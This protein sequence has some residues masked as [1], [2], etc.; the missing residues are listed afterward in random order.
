MRKKLLS[1]IL[2]AAMSVSLFGCG[3]TRDTADDYPVEIATETTTIE[4]YSKEDAETLFSPMETIKIT[5][6]SQV[7]V[8]K[9]IILRHEG[10]ENDGR[11][12]YKLPLA[13]FIQEGD[14]INSFTFVVE[15]SSGNIGEFK[16]AYGIT[17]AEDCPSAT[18]SC[19]H[20]TPDFT[21][22]TN[23]GYAELT[24]N[25]PNE[26]AD[27]VTPNGDVM[28]GYW[29]GDA[30]IIKLGYV[31]CTF[32][33]TKSVPYKGTESKAIGET[34]IRR[35]DNED[36]DHLFRIKNDFLPE[37]VVP[38]L[39]TYSFS[40][41]GNIKK[42]N[43]EFGFES[44]VNRYT[45]DDVAVWVDGNLAEISWF[46]PVEVRNYVA[47]KGEY[48]FDY[49]W[50]E[51]SEITL[52]KITVVYSNAEESSKT[53]TIMGGAEDYSQQT[54]NTSFRRAREISNAIRVGWNLG[55][56]LE[57]YNTGLSGLETET[58][59]GNPITTEGM[60]KSVK[61]AGFNAVRIPV[62][63]AEHMD[64]YYNIDAEWLDRIQEVVDYA[65]N[66]DM[67]VIV[68][69]HHDDYIWFVPNEEK[70]EENSEKLKAIWRQIAN[71]FIDYG[72]RLLF[73]G[74]NEPRTVGS[75]ME[76]MGGTADERTVVNR[77]ENDFVETVR[78][79][80]GNNIDRT[81]IVTSYAASAETVAINDVIV[82]KENGNIIFSVHYYAPWEF[83]EGKITDFTDQG[84]TQLENKFKEL[85]TKFID[86]GTP[87]IID[88]FGCGTTT[89]EQTRHDYYNYYITT[90][91]KYG[92]KCFVWD[93]G[94]TEG[95]DGFGI[96][97]REDNYKW[98]TSVL[99]GIMDK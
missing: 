27:Y 65:Y 97:A 17:V 84:K 40:A 96:F 41:N 60:I 31:I 66:S 50:S 98:N 48:L 33:R 12:M 61:E 45:G 8:Q 16:G 24:W 23:G 73:E 76:W 63:W 38:Q 15:S 59:W 94:L 19:F 13:D 99:T 49:G 74:M 29:W 1:A 81:L 91:R 78:A 75:S 83:T 30:E 95:K 89:S 68:N 90:A 58:G 32:T 42:I 57:S 44:I 34:K 4:N 3:D 37:G 47:N 20:Q 2:A 87:V 64:E 72:D 88:E 52:D 35:S 67:F 9:E 39:V 79:T 85:K 36:G 6:G 77:Y 46:V 51:Q 18:S 54:Y 55:N 21:E 7:T 70:Y 62:T 53:E 28:F 56:T 86:N 5:T 25:V 69:M 92:I 82:P 93:N 11:N 14:Y 22:G 43:G 10:D 80:G 26:I 71:R